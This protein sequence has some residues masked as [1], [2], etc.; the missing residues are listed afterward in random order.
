MKRLL[1]ILG[2]VLSMVG[3]TALNAQAT[4]TLN[5]DENGN[6]TVQ[7]IGDGSYSESGLKLL[8]TTNGI[9]GLSYALPELVANGPISIKD[10]DGSISDFLIFGTGI[11]DNGIT[12]SQT[13]WFYS[14]PGPDLADLS[15]SDWATAMSLYSDTIFSAPEAADGTFSWV[16]H[17]Y[18]TSG[19][20]AVPEPSTILLL[21]VG[22]SAL[23]A[24][25]TRSR[26]A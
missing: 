22:L 24:F 5:F 19:P 10:P 20:S 1:V 23:V 6:A 12:Q 25:K 26:R 18:G 7:I 3:F 4:F 8:N 21:G 9:T 14:D 17:Y 11:H 13:M 15:A 16:D 2:M